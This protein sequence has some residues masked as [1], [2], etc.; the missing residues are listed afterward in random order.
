MEVKGVVTE[1][2]KNG[3]AK[4]MIERASAC[5]G[6]CHNC[7]NSCGSKSE[8]FVKTHESVSVGDMVMVAE[9]SQK[10]LLI[11]TSVFIIP[12]L[13][14]IFIYNLTFNIYNNELL[15]SSVAFFGGILVF[16][17][18]VIIFRKLKMPD[19]TKCND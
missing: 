16:L 7:L 13:S 9:K 12:L 10:V 1:V 18:V 3:T 8:I 19:C 5:G 15:S 2:Y 17:I 4:V 14:L 11:S 6:N